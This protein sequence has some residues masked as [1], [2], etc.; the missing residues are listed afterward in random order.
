MLGHTP[1]AQKRQKPET[2]AA[3]TKG[4]NITSQQQRREIERGR[5]GGRGGKGGR[6]EG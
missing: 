1:V 5:E 4:E 2:P 6:R 3:M